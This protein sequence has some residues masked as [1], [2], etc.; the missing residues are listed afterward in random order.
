MSFAVERFIA[1]R[2]LRSKRKEVF[3]S[4]ITVISFLGVALSVMVLDMMLAAMTGLE[5]EIQAKFVDANA[6]IVVRR[7]D[8]NIEEYESVIKRIAQVEGVTAVFPFTYNQAMISTEAGSRGLLI[9]GVAPDEP[10]K[11][12]LAKMMRAGNVDELFSSVTV[13]V[14]RPDGS[15]N[16]VT[17]PGLVVGRALFDSL[18]LNYRLPVTLFSPQ[19]SASPQGMIP[20]LKRFVVLGF[21]SSGL[22]EYENGLAYASLKDAQTFFGLGN[23]V[24]G[25]EVSVRD[26]FKAKEIGLKISQALGGDESPYVITDWSAQNKPLWDAMRLEKQVYFLVLLLLVLVA[27]FSIV[28]ALVMVVMEKIKDVAILK[29]MGASDRMVLKV[30]LIQGMVIGLIGVCLGSLFGYLGCVAL[31]E[32]GFPLNEKVFSL[33]KLPVHMYPQ[34]F[35]LVAVCAFIITASAGIYPALRAARLRPADAL[36]FE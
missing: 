8:G 3:I 14:E 27:S 1:G 10:S 32:Y 11:A 4:I 18:G 22:M 25:V 34:H 31:R 30:F 15:Q 12:K 9:R 13:P 6:H 35:A 20:K 2:Y 23:S 26:W 5:E 19:F 36:R 7:I 21:Y 17:L 24:S 16:Q 28:S 33:S 29:S